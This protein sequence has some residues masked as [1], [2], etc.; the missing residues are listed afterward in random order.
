MRSSG[1]QVILVRHG[2]T[3]WSRNGRHTS[4]TDLPL[5]LGGE[6]EAKSLKECLSHWTFHLALS[7]PRAR[8]LRTAELAGWG[9]RVEI[10]PDLSEWN[11]GQYE[12]QTTQEIRVADPKW[13]VFR[14]QTPGGESSAQVAD[15]CDRVRRRLR[16]A[17][18]D[19]L[20]FAHS[21]VLRVLIARWLELPAEDGRH[22][23]IQT[24]TLGVL[25]YEHESPVLLSLNATAFRQ[26]ERMGQTVRKKVTS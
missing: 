23:V 4:F 11:Y 9:G 1:P 7:S 25:S 17:A 18:G 15:R 22:F 16:A 19:C 24:G 13:T 2:E 10:D 8:A 20:L 14:G 5:T 21:H 3:E 12:G 6:R 26:G